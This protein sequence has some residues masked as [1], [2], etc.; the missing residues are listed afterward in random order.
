MHL[1]MVLSV[2]LVIIAF[3]RTLGPVGIWMLGFFAVH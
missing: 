2:F 1:G 3:W